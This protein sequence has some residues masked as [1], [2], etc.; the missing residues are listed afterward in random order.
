MPPPLPLPTLLRNLLQRLVSLTKNRLHPMELTF[1]AQ[2]LGP[3]H[4]R[5]GMVHQ[6][7]LKHSLWH[8]SRNIIVD[9]NH[10]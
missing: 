5:A 2:T 3:L 1:G 9:P 6:T 4:G 8:W 7:R 10:T